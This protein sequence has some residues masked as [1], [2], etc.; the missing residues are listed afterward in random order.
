[1]G[2]I[3]NPCG[4]GGVNTIQVHRKVTFIILNG[5]PISIANVITDVNYFNFFVEKLITSP[6]QEPDKP[7]RFK[8]ILSHYPLPMNIYLVTLHMYGAYGRHLRAVADEGLQIR[9]YDVIVSLRCR[10][11]VTSRESIDYGVR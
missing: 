10:F 5:S 6:C 11:S 3:Y 4:G 1:M 8:H 2:A 7:N 9:G